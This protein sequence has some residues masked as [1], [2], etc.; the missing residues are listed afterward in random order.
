MSCLSD[1]TILVPS[2][3]GTRMIA[4]KYRLD[5]LLGRGGMGA[6]YLGTHVDLDRLVAIKLLLPDFTADA[7]ALERFRREA[8]AA[9]RLNHPN[10]A[11]T[12]DYGVLPDGGA[13]I[14]MEMVEGQTLREYMDASG[15]LPIEE[16]VDIAE[17]VADGIEAAHRRDIVH[18][19]LKP[20]NIIL[21]RDHQGQ[22]QAKVVDFGVAKLKEQTTTTGGLTASGSLIGTPRYMSPEQCAGLKTDGRSDIYSMGVILYEMLAGRP[23]FDAPTATAIAIKHIQSEPPPLSEFRPGI[24]PE[25]EQFVRQAL[26]KDPEKRPQTAASFGEQLLKIIE[27]SK[28]HHLSATS[29]LSA[30]SQ[31]D[32]HP[33]HGS[34]TRPFAASSKQTNRI[35]GPTAEYAPELEEQRD[36]SVI[37]FAAQPVEVATETAT[38]IAETSATAIA[39]SGIS[40]AEVAQST[41]KSEPV[42]TPTSAHSSRRPESSWPVWAIAPIV[43][44]IIVIA[45]WFALSRTSNHE[46]NMTATPR[47]TT[48]QQTQAQPT[49]I[50]SDEDVKTSPNQPE[51]GANV[52]SRVND[53]SSQE[54]AS[55][56]LKTALDGWLA[57]TNARDLNQ[58]ISFYAPVL[59]IFYTKRNVPLSAVRAEKGRLISQINSIDVRAASTEIHLAPDGLSATMRFRKSWTYSGAQSQSGEVIQELTWKKID[60]RWKIAGERDLEVIRVTR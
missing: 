30:S 29:S 60:S 55:T 49:N 3:H 6:V 46:G 12:Y 13:Y 11:D 47:E 19:D 25:I 37:S 18:R 2:R 56:E 32:K 41:N 48:E 26:D 50:K 8:R 51:T 5:R 23:P 44:A 58:Q 7:D 20:S 4:D 15:P 10:V 53:K 40:E 52:A 21:T 14:V 16:A 1:Q 42:T 27:D 33:A 24:T 9:A 39:S 34:E 17:Q 57:A 31:A 28:Q 36:P 22:L 59:A 43:L 45:V 54:D 38:K 35:S